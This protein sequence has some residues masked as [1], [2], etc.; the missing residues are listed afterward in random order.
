M[1]EPTAKLAALTKASELCGGE[2]AQGLETEWIEEHRY[3]MT[4]SQADVLS[5]LAE[6]CAE[7]NPEQALDALERARALD[8]DAE[9]TYLRII[10]IQLDLDHKDDARR[11]AKLL[12]QHQSGLGIPFDSRTERVLVALL[13]ED[14]E[15][16]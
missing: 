7:E 4:R 9:E 14:R 6:R 13:S 16:A 12:R 2:L 15:R 11:T 1:S 3:P 8:P 5:Q 10:R